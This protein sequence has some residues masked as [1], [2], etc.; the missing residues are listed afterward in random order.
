M[1]KK[2]LIINFLKILLYCLLGFIFNQIN[3]MVF[4]GLKIYPNFFFSLI[5]VFAYLNN[6]IWSFVMGLLAGFFHDW[7][8]SPIIGVGIFIGMLTSIICS[9]FLQ[10][11][12]QRR[13]AF[14]FVQALIALLVTK[15]LEAVFNFLFLVLQYEIPLKPHYIGN[16]FVRDLP[17]TIGVNMLATILWFLILRFLLPYEK[18]KQSSEFD[19]FYDDTREVL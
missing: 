19:S 18:P 2:N 1:S 9:S 17:L 3:Q 4:P 6:S 14:L 15:F 10:S 5:W 13:S 7:L 12:W 11:V 16:D 8:F